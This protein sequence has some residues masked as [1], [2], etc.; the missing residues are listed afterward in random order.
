MKVFTIQ[1]IGSSFD[2]IIVDY[3]RRF[4]STSILILAQDNMNYITKILQWIENHKDKNEDKK[5]I[6]IV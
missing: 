4:Q 1:A 2:S 6:K 5:D 3:G